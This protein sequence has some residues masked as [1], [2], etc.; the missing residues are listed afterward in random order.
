MSGLLHD[1]RF[2][3]RTLFRAPAFTLIAV[4]TLALGIGASAGI[5]MVANALLVKPLPY[6]DADRLVM[7][8]ADFAAVGIEGYPLAGPE[9]ADIRGQGSLFNGFEAIW[10]SS[11]SISGQGD[12][13]H[14]AVGF[15]TA[16]FLSL[17]G[18]APAL[19]RSF[20]SQEDMPGGPR[21]LVISDGLWRR[22]YGGD[23]DIVSKNVQFNGV[24]YAVVGVM[25]AGYRLYFPEDANVPADLDV[26]TP[27]Q[28]D[29][30]ASRR[31]VR[32]LRTVGR[33]KAGVS[34]E[35]AQ[36][37]MTGIAGRMAGEHADYVD[38]DFN[39]HVVGLHAETV[40]AVRPSVLALMVGVGFLLL[41]SCTNFTNLLLVRG[42]ERSGEMAIRAALGAGRGRIIRQMLVEH[43]VLAVAAGSLGLLFAVWSVD[44]PRVLLA[45][46]LPMLKNIVVDGNVLAFTLLVSI[47]IPTLFGL[48][49]AVRAARQDL[50]G[51]LKQSARVSSDRRQQRLRAGLAVGTISLSLVLLIGAGLMIRTFAEL[52]SV[53][54]GFDPAD[55]LTFKVAPPESRYASHEA[56][57]GFYQRLETRLAALPGVDAAG[58]VSHVP[59]DTQSNWSGSYKVEADDRDDFEHQADERVVTPGYFKAIG[60][61]LREGRLFDESDTFDS[62]HVVIVDR[63]LAE[64]MWPND[65]ALGK[66]IHLEV[67]LNRRFVPRKA[68]I[69]G[70]IE[71]IRT[72]DLSREVR[73]QIYVP[74]AQASR[75]IMNYTIRSSSRPAGLLPAIRREVAAMDKGLPI[76]D[77]R[78]LDEYVAASMS[79][80]RFTMVLAAVFAGVALLLA[81]GGLYGVISYS[82]SRRTNEF[83]IRMALG[84]RPGDILKDVLGR[85]AR[86]SLVGVGL[87]LVAAFVLT[88]L[89]AGFVFGISATDPITYACTSVFLTTIALGASYLPARRATKVNPAVA[90][91]CE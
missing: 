5:F 45:E 43:L 22:R 83:G 27:L 75:W 28:S 18:V 63:L 2:T 82:V 57:S 20:T 76:Y 21:A 10:A 72:H 8:R 37:E 29:Y 86:L 89:L 44:I 59:F 15:V 35:Q 36:A 78:G 23:A 52:R 16:D 69:V 84:A 4:G 67:T 1:L 17:M 56:L 58:A 31:D 50:S 24:D 34:L 87:G 40:R 61:R 32:Y 11:G 85:S 3:C 9:L 73:E 54:P 70:V 19:G 13:E 12:P 33:L 42:A 79:D 80:V 81:S 66:Q 39:L 6:P 68:E 64:R 90:L 71:H 30:A 51:A 65:H 46:N 53:Q 60:A 7:V 25:P 74:G 48:G 14:V 62:Q 41:I 91:R 49:P 55:V 38:S 77:V 88:P 47:L 26:W